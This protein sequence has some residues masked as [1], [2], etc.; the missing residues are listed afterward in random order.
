MKNRTKQRRKINQKSNIVDMSCRKNMNVKVEKVYDEEEMRLLILE[1]EK[2][3]KQMK[4]MEQRYYS[5]NAH[6]ERIKDRNFMDI[7]CEKV[8]SLF[9]KLRFRRI[10]KK[11]LR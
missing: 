10:S 1:L 8:D 5:V 2:Q 9:G 3:M 4:E 6:I 11:Y 7:L